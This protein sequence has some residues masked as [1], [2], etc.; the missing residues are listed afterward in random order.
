MAGD[1]PSNIGGYGSMDHDLPWFI[2]A[3]NA[4]SGQHEVAP[5][6]ANGVSATRVP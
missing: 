6:M 4:A 5:P 3:S 1:I 2:T